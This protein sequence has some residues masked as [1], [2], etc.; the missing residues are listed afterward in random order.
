MATAS[1]GRTIDHCQ[2]LDGAPFGRTVKDEVHRSHL[3]GCYRT[4]QR[5]VIGNRYT[6]KLL[7]WSQ[8]MFGWTLEVIKR[9][10]QHRFKVLPKRWIVERTFA[11][12]NQ[13]RRLS[14]D[15][16]VT[17]AS[18]GALVKIACIRLMIRRLA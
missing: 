9:N 12:L 7:E 10:E 14:R 2:V 18:A 6:G 15:Y 3:V 13:P 1:W 5:V 4:L 16:Q 17:V 11:W 8:A